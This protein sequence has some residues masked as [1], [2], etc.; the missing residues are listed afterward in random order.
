[1]KKNILITAVL[2]L[3]CL[4]TPSGGETAQVFKDELGRAVTLEK[5]PQRIVSLAPNVTEILFALG[6]GD[7][8]VGVTNFCNYPEEA[9]QKEKVGML[10]NPNIEKILTLKPDL[11]VWNTEGENK[12]TFI[13]L[14]KLGL[15]IFI[16]SPRTIEA[17][18]NSIINV[19]N[20]CDKRKEA[21][22]LVSSMKKRLSSIEEKLKGVKKVKVLFLLDLK[23]LISVSK[24]SFHGEMIEFAKGENIESSSPDRYPRIS[25]EEVVK[26]R[27]DVIIVSNHR[28]DFRKLFA[29]FKNNPAV[30]ATPAFENNRVHEVKSDLVDRLAPRIIYGFEKLAKIIHPE[31]FFIEP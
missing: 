3:I 23:P 30:R 20:V 27:P 17:L 10:L 7:K 6:L 9:K 12:Q 4:I 13:K 18:F 26:Q 21:E 25:W 24:N 5:A 11:V 16:I 22:D 2:F 15:K 19:G 14:S 8:V 28:E 29:E 31:A 1:M